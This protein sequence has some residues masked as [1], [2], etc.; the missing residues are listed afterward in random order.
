[1]KNYQSNGNKCESNLYNNYPKVSIIILNWN[2]VKDTI[3]CIEALEKITYTNYDIIVVDNGSTGDD[4][5]ILERKYG[6]RI[7]IIANDENYGLS[8]GR[9]IGIRHA[10]DD[11]AEY[12]QILDNDVLVASDFLIQLIDV[13]QSDPSIG[14]VGPMIYYY[15]EPNK[16]A[17]AGRYI[18]YWTGFIRTRGVGE[19]DRGQ[20]NDIVD[21]DCATGGTML[22]SREALATV[23]PLDE[24]FFFWYED[25]EFCTR[26]IKARF[27]VVLAP[28]AK[29]W[30]KKIKKEKVSKNVETKEKVAIS[31]HYF[32]RNRFILMKK[33]CN[34]LQLVSAT[35][36]FIF[37]VCP[38]LLAK[39]IV[40]YRSLAMLGASLKG[41]C[42]LL[43]GRH[44]DD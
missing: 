21:V 32:I 34:R 15:E 12:V 11:K 38:Q 31:S 18:N 17:Y 27:K 23:G 25:V 33:H 26:V 44:H 40:H 10:L 4:V 7:C 5:E 2:G 28:R 42:G 16:V 35:F 30:V 9:N 19:I 41:I 3:E 6:E 24:N 20:F 1:M 13:A 14:I 39:Y 43:L 37:F 29:M 8:K 22:I 36:C